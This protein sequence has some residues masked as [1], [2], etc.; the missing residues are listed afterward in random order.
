MIIL[1]FQVAEEETV[2]EE[3]KPESESA[4]KDTKV[5]EEPAAAEEEKP[6]VES[7]VMTLPHCV[8]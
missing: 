6:A 4:V 3:T 8:H 2:K 7:N 5:V 1:K